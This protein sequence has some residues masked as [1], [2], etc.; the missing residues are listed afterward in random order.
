MSKLK[1]NLQ[2]LS[3]SRL[4]VWL[5]LGLSKHT[6]PWLGY[7]IANLAAAL[8]LSRRSSMLIR[9]LR[10]NQWVLSGGRLTG[11]ALERAVREIM[12]AHTRCLYDFYHNLDRP[13]EVLRLVQFDPKFQDLFEQA[14]AGGGPILFVTPHTSNFDLAGRAMALRGLSFQVLSYPQ[15]PKGYQL[16]NRIRQE[17]GLEMTPMSVASVQQARQRL[18]NGGVV[19]TGLDRPLPETKL[20]PRFFGRPAPLPVA[21]THLAL[22]ADAPMV[23]VACITT[24]PSRYQVICSPPVQPRRYPDRDTELLENTQA[25]LREAE[26]IIR[27]HARQWSMF[28]PVWPETLDQVN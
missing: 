27:D 2:S 26:I 13:D 21:Y 23:V 22:Q 24:A 7:R 12:Y 18:R 11:Q 9:S 28:Y 25:V 19:L 10:A 17:S 1:I 14:K 8:A 15:P 3:N 6:P 16:Q 5:A 20:M 4:G